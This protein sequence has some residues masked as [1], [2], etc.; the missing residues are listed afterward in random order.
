MSFPAVPQDTMLL[1]TANS[2]GTFTGVTTDET[3]SI[4]VRPS[5]HD[6]QAIVLI[7]NGTTSGGNI[8]IE[9]AF[10]FEEKSGNAPAQMPYNGTWS[11]ILVVAASTL[12]GG[13][14]KIV[15]VIGPNALFR[16][17]V[18]ISD[19]ITGGGGISAALRVQ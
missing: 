14:Q 2:D 5:Q 12:T 9:E 10:W 19:A 8:T 18:R 15:H 1:G 6:A 11:T 13:A 3:T 17:R 16:T 4:A 7:S